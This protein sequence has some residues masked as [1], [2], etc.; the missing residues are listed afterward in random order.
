MD[1]DSVLYGRSWFPDN[2]C[3]HVWFLVQCL[4]NYWMDCDY[5]VLL[6]LWV[7]M[8]V[9]VITYLAKY[10]NIYLVNWPKMWFRPSCPPLDES[11]WL[12]MFFF[13]SSATMRVT[14]TS[15]MDYGAIWRGWSFRHSIFCSLC[16]KLLTKMLWSDP[17]SDW[18]HL[19]VNIS[20]LS[21]FGLFNV[22][23]WLIFK[24]LFS[25]LKQTACFQ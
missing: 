16:F 1:W 15:W 17:L 5:V 12:V 23:I 22:I 14:L 11:Y 7:F 2:K 10:P 3:W 13:S 20:S 21:L 9:K 24:I 8:Y 18:N 25:H 4:N 6:I 19:P